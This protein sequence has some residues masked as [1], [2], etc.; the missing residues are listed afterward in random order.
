L[1]ET[2]I[3]RLI[4]NQVVP[5]EVGYVNMMLGKKQLKEVIAQVLAETN[6]PTTAKF[7]DDIK[8]LGF[9]L[10]IQRWF[11]LQLD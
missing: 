3:G 8:K 9:Y 2:T 5:A 4:F 7:L 1:I 11:E 6:I 10:F